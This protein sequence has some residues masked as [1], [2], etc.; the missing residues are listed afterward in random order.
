M[1]IVFCSQAFVVNSAA[2][3]AVRSTGWIRP[4]AAPRFGA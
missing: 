2:D 4:S 1:Q 3:P